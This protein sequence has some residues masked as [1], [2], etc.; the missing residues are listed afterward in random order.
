MVDWWVNQAVQRMLTATRENK[1]LGIYIET[2]NTV[3]CSSCNVPTI[4][5]NL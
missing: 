5:R 2:K 3:F 4:L 1:D